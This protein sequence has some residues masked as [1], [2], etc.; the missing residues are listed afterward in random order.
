MVT[1]EIP[2]TGHSYA[3]SYTAPTC[4]VNGG[5]TYT[6]PCGDVYTEVIAA[7]GHSYESVSVAPTCT[8]D[9]YTMYTCA[10]CGDS[11]T[12]NEIA[13]LGHSYES[14]VTNPT[15]TKTGYTTYTCT[16][17]GN[18]YTGDTV[19]A[20]GHSYDSTV[21]EATCTEAGYTTY[22]CTFCGDSYT[23]NNVTALG[24]SYNC[25]E[26]N[27]YL[28]YTCDT[29]GHSYS[30][31]IAD[32][33]YTKV[34]SLS[35]DNNYVITLYSS[36]KYYALTH[37]DNKISVTQVTVSNN[38]ITSEIT[39]DMVW[40]Y[41]GTKLS[42]ED[43]DTTYYLYAQS[44]GG[45]FGWGKTPTLTLSTSNSTSVSFSNSKLNLSN[46]YL[47]YSSGNVSLNRSATT[48]YCFIEE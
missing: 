34:S 36:R 28:V 22:T 8:A 1:E 9:G 12:T 48:T 44:S 25:V 47:R 30:E 42:Y 20:L 13:A 6:C 15:C 40:T 29:C 27:G 2:A 10:A 35:G 41:S 7:L 4:T 33:T 5:T 32:L 39:E 11:Y 17:C 24:H 43:G 23:G 18:S 45:W 16:V 38:E 14:T 31:E 46:Y 21:T 37:E 19:A 3:S 26:S